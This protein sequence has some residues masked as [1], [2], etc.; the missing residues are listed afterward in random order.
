[1]VGGSTFLVDVHQEIAAGKAGKECIIRLQLRLPDFSEHTAR[2]IFRQYRRHW[3]QRLLSFNIPLAPL[4]TLLDGTFA[5][6][7]R[8]FM[9]IKCWP[10]IKFCPPT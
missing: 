4:E 5:C 6:F 2:A 1:M 7:G 8:Q 10:N 3:E 9:Q